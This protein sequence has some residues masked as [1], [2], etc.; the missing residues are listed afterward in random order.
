MEEDDGNIDGILSGIAVTILGPVA[1][2]SW[3]AFGWL[4]S[5][6]WTPLPVSKVFDW[7]G[8]DWMALY[9]W[10]SWIGVGKTL[11]WML[12]APLSASIALLGM[13][14]IWIAADG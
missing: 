2:L 7:I 10:E 1:I 4:R 14:W 8:I 11:L 13:I 6:D 3:Q 12:E 9:G 5:G